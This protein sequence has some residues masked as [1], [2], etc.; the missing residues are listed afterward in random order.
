MVS[1]RFAL[2]VIIRIILLMLTLVALAFIFA[3][4]ELFFNQIILLGVIILQVSELIRFVT[5]TNRELAKLLLAIRYSD[6]SISFKGGKRGKSFRELQEAFVEIIEAF[7]KVSVEKEAQFRF[8]KVI[9]DNIKVGVVAIKEEYSIELMNEGAQEMLKISTPNYWKQFHQLLPHLAQEIEDMEDNEKRLIELNIKEERLQISAQVNRLKI[10]GYRYTIVT[11]QDIKSEIEQKEI[12]AW[13]KL[14]RV[15]THEI[16][17]SV[18]PVTSLTETML[19]LT[20]KDGVPLPLNEL[21][22]ETLEDLRFSMKTIQKRSEGLLHFVDDY[23]RLTKIKALELEEIQV[24]ELLEEM[25][26]LLSS[27]AE[28]SNVEIRISAPHYLRIKMDR[29]LIEQVLINLIT[30][31]RHALEG[32]ENGTI[33]LTAYEDGAG[34]IIEVKDN[35]TGI[36]IDKQEEIFVPF[37]STKTEGSGIGLSLSKQI[38]KKHKGDLTVKSEIGVGSRFRLHF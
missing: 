5:Y 23:R 3:R 6:F 12:E 24:S 14:I 4:T 18:T 22:E 35:G 31:A 27:E 11:F 7:K 20:E 1:K 38:M 25:A 29:K 28:K 21:T 34:Q 33:T 26:V 15:L 13:H 9:I 8:L 17:N 37:Y 36:E 16:M 19:M 30:N 32:S 10:L 2:L